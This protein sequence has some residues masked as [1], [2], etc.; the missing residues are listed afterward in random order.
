[1]TAPAPTGRVSSSR[2]APGVRSRYVRVVQVAHTDGVRK[3]GLRRETGENGGDHVLRNRGAAVR[4]RLRSLR[5]RLAKLLR[6][7]RHASVPRCSLLRQATCWRRRDGEQ[8]LQQ[9]GDPGCARR[10]NHASRLPTHAVHAAVR[11]DY[12]QANPSCNKRRHARERAALDESAT[13]RARA[14]L[15][16]VR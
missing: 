10:R 1:M 16:F 14:S 2:G 7:R 5:K 6:G 3:H 12:R 9:T 11:H 13:E 8:R 15:S 4:H